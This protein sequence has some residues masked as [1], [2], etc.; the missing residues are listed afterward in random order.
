MGTLKDTILRHQ[1]PD[2]FRDT[3]RY[4]VIGHHTGTFTEHL[5]FVLTP[6]GFSHTGCHLPD[7]ACQ[8]LPHLFFKGAQCTLQHGVLRDHVGHIS[9]GKLTDGQ[10]GLVC[11]ADLSGNQRLQRQINLYRRVD[12]IYAVFR[13]GAVS[14]TAGEGDFEAVHR[15][16]GLLTGHHDTYRDHGDHMHGKGGIHMGLL[17][18]AGFHG[19]FCALKYLLAGLKQQLDGTLKLF[20]VGLQELCRSQQDCGVHIMA[21]AVHTS[22]F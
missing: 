20:F 8:P 9:C 5:V 12:G 18:N 1:R 3:C 14:T 22:V 6:V 10:H 11:S 17:Q 19:C 15:G 4:R 21:A 7:A 13:H 16:H 2:G